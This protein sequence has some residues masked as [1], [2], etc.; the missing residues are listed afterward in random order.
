MIKDVHEVKSM[1]DV[2]I[3]EEALN[4][5]KDGRNILVRTEGEMPNGMVT[6]CVA[7]AG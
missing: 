7:T 6:F 5:V 1:V 4:A 2:L 3:N